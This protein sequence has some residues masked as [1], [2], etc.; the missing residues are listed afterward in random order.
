MS[1]E[2]ADYVGCSQ[3]R[4]SIHSS[5]AVPL[6]LTRKEELRRAVLR[7]VSN[8]SPDGLVLL[9]STN[10]REWHEL[11][12][13]LDISG[14]A[15]YL[16]D[17]LRGLGQDSILP[18]SVRRRLKENLADNTKRTRQMTAEAV[19][20]RDAFDHAR[21]SFALLKGL[22]L[23]PDSVV[24]PELRSQ[25]DI[26]FLVGPGDMTTARGI[27]ESRGYYL[28]AVSGRSWEFKTHAV[29]SGSM[30]DLY[31]DVPWRSVELHAELADR[32]DE[33]RLTRAERHLAGGVEMPVL[34]ASD[35]FIEQGLHLFKHVSSAS[36][37][38]SHVVEFHR[39][40]MARN[41]EESFWRKVEARAA[42]TGAAFWAL[43]A[44]T[45]LAEQMLG[46]CA[47]ERFTRWTVE[48]LSARVR[49]WVE[50]YGWRAALND[51]PG[52]KLYVLLARELEREG[53]ETRN[54]VGSP[55]MES[56]LSVE[57]RSARGAIIPRRLPQMVVRGEPGEPLLKKALRFR[58]QLR[59][60]LVRLRF[61]VVE[62]L[63]LAMESLHW[64]K[65]LK[66]LE[67]ADSSTIC[68]VNKGMTIR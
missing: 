25:L 27:L 60:I 55:M 12:R 36:Y 22:S 62:G 65:R 48:R 11:L 15:L 4:M 53:L 18:D 30:R 9:A 1:C 66:E 29:P 67:E 32:G 34:C 37:R 6:R 52:T 58:L 7:V 68:M 3:D 8:A 61:H 2:V 16:Y 23:S 19:A 41:G 64:R 40:L 50:V 54:S 45:L 51:I 17:R 59:F 63:R 44:V 13:W 39:N 49:L 26:D 42:E 14:I 28:H 31:R 46:E 24:R 38:A 56:E 33:L 57:L 47:P 21:L 35:R 43:G 20:I 5:I 10:D